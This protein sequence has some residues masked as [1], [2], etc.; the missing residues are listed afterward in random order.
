MFKI[1]QWRKC[2]QN[3]YRNHRVNLEKMTRNWVRR[4]CH[5]EEM[6]AHGSTN[7]ATV[8]E[9]MLTALIKNRYMLLRTVNSNGPQAFEIRYGLIPFS[10]TAQMIKNKSVLL[11]TEVI[12]KKKH[13]FGNLVLYICISDS[14]LEKIGSYSFLYSPGTICSGV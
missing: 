10:E 9:N 14:K 5:A 13:F 7:G 6:G 8:L 1:D 3:P 2:H 12:I 11:G 4:T